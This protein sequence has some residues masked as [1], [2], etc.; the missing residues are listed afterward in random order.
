F[1]LRAEAGL[2]SLANGRLVGETL[3]DDGTRTTEWRLDSRCPSYLTCFVV[4]D[5]VSFKDESLGELPIEY[6]ATR[7]RT[8]EDLQRSFGRTGEM[9]T[10]LQ[11]KLGLEFPYPK[12]FQFALPGFGGAMENIS[13]VS[14]DDVFVMDERMATE[15]TWLVDQVNIHEMAHSY[16]GDLIVCRDFAH[17]WLKESW[18]TYI[19]MCW[20]EHK[21]GREEADY[22]FYACSQLYIEEADSRYIRPLVTR[23][24]NSSWQMYDRHLY[25]GGAARLHT[26][27][28][29]LGDETFWR[30]V[31]AYVSKYASKL[32]ETDDFRKEM[33]A[34]SGRSL[35]RFFDQWLHSPGYPSF[36]VTFA[37]DVEQGVGN[38]TI[39]Q[40]QEN[41]EK[42]VPLFEVHVELGW[43]TAEGTFTR[44][45]HLE[46]AKE[47]FSFKMVKPTMVRFDPNA[48][49][50]HKLEFDPGEEAL[51]AQLEASDVVGR[52]HAAQMLIK[53]GKS[54]NIKRVRDAYEQESFWGVKVEIAGALGGAQTQSALTALCALVGSESDPMVMG[55]VFKAAGRYRDPNIALALE[56]RLNDPLPY[57]AQMSALESLGLQRESAPLERLQA[58]ARVDG[59]GG[60][61]QSGALRGLGETRQQAAIQTLVESLR[62]GAT[63]NRA[64][65]AAAT[66]LGTLAKSVR[67]S[68]RE[69]IIEVLI[70]HLRDPD[71]RVAAACAAALASADAGS[72]IEALE[73]YGNGLSHQQQVAVEG[74][75]A[76]IRSAAK[77]Q[78][79]AT[80]KQVEELS[81]KVR[82]LGEQIEELEAKLSLG[83]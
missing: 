61:A 16:F 6:F 82:R 52:I 29:E 73:G 63:S 19:E 11:G 51:T 15:L 67:R 30:G 57:R 32:V 78:D 24:F 4:G 75:I 46:H 49:V 62:Y 8:P 25:P 41:K 54:K 59:F 12:Y 69:R 76:R 48:T 33:E 68:E 58:A 45:V 22:D 35:G 5:L 1:Q 47:Q 43:T 56:Q 81:A 3:H 74:L 37:H 34:A 70:D 38:F 39:E 31:R 9:L 18:A 42:G 2:V 21:R 44:R 50:L 77:P 36:K 26:L 79:A 40:T 60:H 10:W 28:K 64:R 66:G 14:W 83:K 80:Q 53:T 27:R 13:L 65:P 17:A 23:E 71:E 20:L 7:E 55:S 72:S